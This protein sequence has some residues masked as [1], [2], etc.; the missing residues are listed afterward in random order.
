M[1]RDSHGREAD[2]PTDIG[3]PGWKAVLKRSIGEIKEDNVALLAAGVAFYFW[4][5]LIPAI[6]AAIMIYGLVADPQQIQ[7]QIQSMLSSLSSDAQSVI[8]EPITSAATAGGLSIGVVVSL[9]GVLWTASGGM[10]G[11]IKGIGVAYD[12]P[13]ERNFVVKR[14]LAIL[15]T[16][17]GIVFLAVAVLLIGVLPAVLGTLGLGSIAQT[18][19]NIARWPLL[20]VVIMVALAV[21]Y[22]VGPDRDDPKMR[23]ASLGAVVA[24]ILWLIGSGLFSFYVTNFGSYN[25]T[26]GALAGV[27]ILNLW[28]FLT[29]FV[30]LFGAEI[31][32]ETEAQTRK[33]TTR[34]EP[35]PMGERDAVKADHTANS[36]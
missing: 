1:A 17:G 10:N 27:I 13:D 35:R 19:V 36:P 24:T 20:A 33:D 31:N 23:W 4:L 21:I 14:G 2:R 7:S 34:G 15:L 22:K 9:A 6:I 18:V 5:A 26:Y 16:L 30:V 12:E 3:G 11:L 8:S 25:K 29:A 32:S 28:L